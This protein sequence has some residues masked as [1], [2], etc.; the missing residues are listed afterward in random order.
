MP[1]K[2]IITIGMEIIVG[3]LFVTGGVGLLLNMI[4]KKPRDENNEVLNSANT[5]MDFWKNQA[6][7]YKTISDE[8]DK[9]YNEKITSL[10]KSFTD[11]IAS[12]SREIGE[13]KGQ[14]TAETSQKK[15]YLAIL[16]NRDPETKKFM[17]Y[18]IKA[19]ENQTETNK[20]IIRILSEIHTMTKEEQDRELKVT[21]T[22]IK[23]GHGV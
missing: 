1:V 19:N 3:L 14:L 21:S 10:T 9:T 12:L 7:Q 8:K 4:K 2:D 20:E 18:M 11:Q 5:I 22:I 16:Q 13:L 17:E 23:D 15:E 6:E